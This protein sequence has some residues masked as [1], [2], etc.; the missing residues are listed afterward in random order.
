RWREYLEDW[1]LYK[2]GQF[3]SRTSIPSDW[4]E[5]IPAGWRLPP[6]FLT[7]PH[8]GVGETLFRLT[9]IFHFA[10]NLTSGPLGGASSTINVG[11]RRTAGRSLWVDDPRRTGF[12]VPPTAT[13]DRIDLERHL[14][15]DQLLADPNGIAVDAALEVFELF[16]WDPERATLVNQLES[17][18]QI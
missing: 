9:E 2:S 10:R 11:L 8:L 3:A 4:F 6:D 5:D 7:T 14:S 13:V 1:R 15:S 12:M 17:L 18:N 16:G